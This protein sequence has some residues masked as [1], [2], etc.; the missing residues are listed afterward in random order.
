[1]MILPYSARKNRVHGAAAC[2]ILKP[3]PSPYS[4][5]VKSNETHLVSARVEINHIMA[6]GQDGKIS[7]MYA[8]VII[9]IESVNDLFI[10]RIDKRVIASVTSYEIICAIACGALSSAYF[11]FEAHLDQRMEEKARL[12]MAGVNSP[13]RFRLLS[14]Q[15]M[16]KGVH[17]VR[18]KVRVR[19]G[20]MT[21]I[22]IDDHSG[23]LINNLTE[24]AMDC[25]NP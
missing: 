9:S 10:K 11:E 18:A 15:G 16:G 24:S 21:N 23:S 13:C 12:D 7:H 1:M 8:C 4:P 22:E 5:S 19:I 6:R 20:A 2:S 17:M 3:N 25:N 14:R